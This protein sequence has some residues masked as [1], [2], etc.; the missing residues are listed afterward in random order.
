MILPLPKGI[1]RM[2]CERIVESTCAYYLANMLS[3]ATLEEAVHMRD[4]VGELDPLTAWHVDQW[5]KRLN[6]P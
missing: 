3:H 2:R 6:G 1:G 5:L 4:V